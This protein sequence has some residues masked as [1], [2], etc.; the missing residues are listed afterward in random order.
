MLNFR[1]LDA[2]I[3]LLN[4]T[5][6][7]AFVF[8]GNGVMRLTVKG[9]STMQDKIWKPVVG[10]E[11][12]YEVSDLGSV[13]SLRKKK[14]FI[15]QISFGYHRITLMRNGV[16]KNYLIHRLM[17]EAFVHP[18]PEGMVINHLNGIKNDNR[19]DNLECVTPAENNIHALKTGLRIPSRGADKWSAK[20]T[21][22]QV[23][24]ILQD[25]GNGMARR[26]IVSKYAHELNISIH[27]VDCIIYKKRWKYLANGN[28]D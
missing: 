25:Y 12:L 28:V 24:Q 15:P 27:T 7:P 5:Q 16:P 17:W 20:L 9:N 13:K 23:L 6:N 22:D 8:A 3:T 10:Y 2:K 18:I 19:L 11:G 26:D 14:L 1:L 4:I 21:E